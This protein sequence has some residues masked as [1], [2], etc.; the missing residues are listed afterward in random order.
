MSLFIYIFIQVTTKFK[1][2][3]L[4]NCLGNLPFTRYENQI[5]FVYLPREKDN[6]RK[7]DNL[8][9]NAFFLQK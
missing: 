1:F 8:T 6:S 7:Y 2:L 3:S 9:G 5:S 4:R